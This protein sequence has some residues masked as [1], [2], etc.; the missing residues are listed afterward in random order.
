MKFYADQGDKMLFKKKPVKIGLFGTALV[1]VLFASVS[2]AAQIK[3]ISIIKCVASS[4]SYG[5][6][7]NSPATHPL[8]QGYVQINDDGDVTVQL[9]GALAN[10]T[11]TV[12]VGNWIKMG[13]WQSQFSG[14]ASSC[15]GIGTVKTDGVGNFIGQIK[16]PTGSSFVFPTKTI[17]GQPNF[18]FNN[19]PCSPTQFTTGIVIP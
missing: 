5:C 19:P 6:G 2:N 4:S 3:E 13:G 9:K 1:G 16:T 12:F 10:T 7:S 11:Y 18:A 8:S 17:I 15:G 14:L